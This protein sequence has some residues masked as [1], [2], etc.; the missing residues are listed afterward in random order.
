MVAHKGLDR[1]WEWWCE[2]SGEDSMTMR[3]VRGGLND[4]T[5]SEEVDDSVGHREIFDGKFWHSD[6]VCESLWGLGFA[7]ATQWFIYMG[8]TVAMGISDIIGAVATENHSSDVL[9][10][11]LDHY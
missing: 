10:P 9:L 4:G 11:S 3:R 2:G 5:G 1:G 8:T 6:G 7:K